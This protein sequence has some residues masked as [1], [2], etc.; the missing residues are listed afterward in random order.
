MKSRFLR[1]NDVVR[2]LWFKVSPT[3][4]YR[5]RRLFFFPLDTWE[6]IA[7]KTH[8]YVPPR[9]SVFTGGSAGAAGFIAF[10][11]QQVALLKKH[12]ALKPNHRVLDIGCGVGRTAIG[13]T[14][15]LDKSGSYDGFDVVE[16]GIEWCQ[17]GIGN[18]FSYFNFTHVPLFNDLYRKSGSNAA[19]FSFPYQD[20][21]FDKLFSFSVF[22]HMGIPEIQNYLHEMNRT[23]KKDAVCF[24]TFFLYNDGNET[25]IASKSGFS[26]PVK[27]DGYRLMSDTT[28]SGNIAI[29]ESLLDSMIKIA[30]FEKVK[31]IHGFWKDEVQD[32]SKEEYQDIVIF[33]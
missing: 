4:R 32:S 13:L 3:M 22:T 12:S 26:F 17:N 6:R 20:N 5:L 11:N 28:V 2:S 30:G 7:G 33:K 8:H 27:K 10:G 9:G 21:S 23:R 14:E 19:S 31:I 18:D 24:S 25:F 1:D 15:F 16:K 29:H